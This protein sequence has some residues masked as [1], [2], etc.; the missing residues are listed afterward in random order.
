MTW[1]RLVKVP[2][3]AEH[4]YPKNQSEETY[5]DDPLLKI[6][7]VVNIKMKGL[8]VFNQDFSEEDENDVEVSV[9]VNLFYEV[10]LDGRSHLCSCMIGWY[11]NQSDTNNMLIGWYIVQ[12]KCYPHRIFVLHKHTN[13]A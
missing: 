10:R 11:T 13:T 2:L 1:T 3:D 9:A 7:N 8:S 4:G 5:S 6:D 12:S